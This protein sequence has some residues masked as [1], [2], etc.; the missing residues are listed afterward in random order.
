MEQ[1]KENVVEEVKESERPF[2]EHLAMEMLK[3]ERIK[4]KAKDIAVICLAA[5]VIVIAI[6]LS[7]INYKNDV[8]WREL[9]GSYDY[10]SQDGEGIN[11]I[12]TGTQGDINNGAESENKDE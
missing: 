10:V 5:S 12:N 7:I 1:N 4:H 9:F 8:D 3:N 6:G 2:S 11:S